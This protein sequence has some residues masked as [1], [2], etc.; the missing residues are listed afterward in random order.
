M[1]K[2]GRLGG[3]GGGAGQLAQQDRQ[4][5]QARQPE[6][7]HAHTHDLI[8]DLR[9][10]VHLLADTSTNFYPVSGILPR[11]RGR[12]LGELDGFF[13]CQSSLLLMS[14]MLANMAM[15]WHLMR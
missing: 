15:V 3:L 12:L 13:S 5:D 14:R 11:E 8:R 7:G 6:E 1:K 2:R 4:A 10:R 9:L